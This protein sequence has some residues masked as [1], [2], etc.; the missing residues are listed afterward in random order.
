MRVPGR[1]GGGAIPGALQGRGGLGR[2]AG[3]G[4]GIGGGSGRARF[5]RGA[6]GRGSRRVHLRA[7]DPI[8]GFWSLRCT[9]FPVS[10]LAR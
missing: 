6:I 1:D 9:S 4:S 2:R 10:A 8:G 3:G 5:A 7:P